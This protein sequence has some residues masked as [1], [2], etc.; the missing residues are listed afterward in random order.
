MMRDQEP[1]MTIGI[2][3]LEKTKGEQSFAFQRWVF[4]PYTNQACKSIAGEEVL[5]PSCLSGEPAFLG[6]YTGQAW[7]QFVLG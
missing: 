5:A 6:L 4:N 2:L 1:T 7:H 3:L